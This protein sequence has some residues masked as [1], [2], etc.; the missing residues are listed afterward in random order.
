MNSSK[1]VM[2]IIGVVL[3]IAFVV[4]MV[5]ETLTHREVSFEPL[6]AQIELTHNAWKSWFGDREDVLARKEGEIAVC[7]WVQYKA[8]LA[9]GDADWEQGLERFNSD[10]MD[11]VMSGSIASNYWASVAAF[12]LLYGVYSGESGREADLAARCRE[13]YPDLAAGIATERAAFLELAQRE[14][15]LDANGKIRPE[16]K[17]I[18]RLLHRHLW[19]TASAY[20]FPRSAIETPEER[21]AFF[22]WQVEASTM[23]P[24]RKL[25]K[26]EEFRIHEGADYDYDFAAAMVYRDAGMYAE[27]CAV[28]R[29]VD[30]NATEFRA[31][32]YETARKELSQAHPGV[33][34]P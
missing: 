33:C 11:L 27:A 6:D 9:T 21:L 24:M 2:L 26:I 1:K 14:G 20:Q 22:R 32:R 30:K 18:V 10:T 8:M 17:E 4:M 5:L 34:N 31:K 13:Y 3:V 29:D 25:K 12:D 16:A 15:M 19:V 7:D 28:L 23:E